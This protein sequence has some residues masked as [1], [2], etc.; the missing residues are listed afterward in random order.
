MEKIFITGIE[1]FVGQYLVEELQ[2]SR[3]ELGGFYFHSAT[4]NHLKKCGAK[5]YPGDVVDKETFWCALGDFRPDAIVHLAG[6]AFV[7]QANSD[8]MNAW[9]VNLMGTL[10][11]L[12]WVRLQKPDTKT[13]IVSSGEVYGAPNSAENLPFTE[14]SPLNPANIYASTKTSLDFASKKYISLWK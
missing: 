12:E 13:I 11:L 4:I 7:P 5:L 2:K 8:P 10:N 1:G 3:Y 6:I 9:R 14:N